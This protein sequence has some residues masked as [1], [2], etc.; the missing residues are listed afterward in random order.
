MAHSDVAFGGGGELGEILLLEGK[1]GVFSGDFAVTAG[2]ATFAGVDVGFDVA[3]GEIAEF[4][5]AVNGPLHEVKF[6]SNINRRESTDLL[7]VIT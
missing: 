3:T 2:Q 1:Q 7:Q 5:A 4:S 6:V